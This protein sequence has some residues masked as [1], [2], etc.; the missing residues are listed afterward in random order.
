MTLAELYPDVAARGGLA[1]ALESTAAE[2]G[3][4][5]GEVRASATEPLRFASVASATPVR[6]ALS[7]HARPDERGWQV[8]GWHRQRIE[9]IRGGVARDL[10][11]VVHLARAWREGVAAREIRRVAPFV[12]LHWLA[13]AVE[14]GP[15][16]TVA[17]QW[18]WV[19]ADARDADWPEHLA[20]VE[21]AHAEPR[22]RA[23]MAVMTDR[24]LRFG[25]EVGWGHSSDVACLE[26]PRGEG[27]YRVKPSYQGAV[28]AEVATPGEAVR[29]AVGRLPDGVGAAGMSVG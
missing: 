6:E 11:E 21:A 15:A 18:E 24:S 1:A 10:T 25:T 29:A 13:D 23:L 26:A 17:A 5:L 8:S 9:L 22:L 16:E 20:M 27:L 14:Q 12:E 28:F 19:F 4:S 3:L 2:H 7:V